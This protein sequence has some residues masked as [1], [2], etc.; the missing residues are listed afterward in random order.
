M[1]HIKMQDALIL[2]TVLRCMDRLTREAVELELHTDNRNREDCVI[3]C[4]S[5]KPLLHLLIE[6]RQFP[7]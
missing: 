7:R 5:W 3:L 4:R 2:S 1:W 6:S